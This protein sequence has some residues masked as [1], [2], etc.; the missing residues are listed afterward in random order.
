MQITF[1]KHF[2]AFNP[3]E[4]AEVDDETAQKLI[5]AGAAT[6]YSGEKSAKPVKDA[7][8]TV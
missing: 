4:T 2:Q 6:A 8:K 3:G 1:T 7:T 5:D